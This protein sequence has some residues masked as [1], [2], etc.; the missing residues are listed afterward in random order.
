[1][2][3]FATCSRRH[4]QRVSKQKQKLHKYTGRI[5]D[6][7]ISSNYPW[8][9]IRNSCFL[10]GR[11]VLTPS[12]IK[13]ESLFME[14]LSIVLLIQLISYIDRIKRCFQCW[15][16]LKCK[17]ED[18]HHTT[19]LHWSWHETLCVSWIGLRLHKF[20]RTTTTIAESS[21]RQGAVYIGDSTTWQ[22]MPVCGP[23][24]EAVREAEPPLYDLTPTHSCILADKWRLQ[25]E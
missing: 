15:P 23:T 18:C 21:Q 3:W 17:E 24:K 7:L 11:A 19:I 8:N 9:E 1:M 10:L 13:K 2:G 5:V 6:G 25:Q 4:W 14:N 22:C 12:I 16:M 20:C